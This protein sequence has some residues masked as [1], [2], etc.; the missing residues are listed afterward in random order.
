MTRASPMLL[1]F[2]IILY[3]A[4]AYAVLNQG[5][6]I[7]RLEEQLE[8]LR[9][10]KLQLLEAANRELSEAHMEV[11]RCRDDLDYWV[12]LYQERAIKTANSVCVSKDALPTWVPKE[13]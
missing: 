7:A 13:E 9:A 12:G 3:V 6:E 10:E 2:T 1:V 11:A 8:I 4:T 5:Q